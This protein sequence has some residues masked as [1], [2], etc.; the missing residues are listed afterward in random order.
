MNEPHFPLHL[1]S[2]RY[3]QTS[4][5]FLVGEFY[6]LDHKEVSSKDTV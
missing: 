3:E 5:F 1:T 4:F 6:A 2:A